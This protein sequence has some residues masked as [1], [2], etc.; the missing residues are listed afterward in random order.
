MSAHPTD[1]LAGRRVLVYCGGSSWDS[2]P[3]TDRHLATH[4]SDRVPV[5]YV[6]PP[7]SVVWQARH[8][9]RPTLRPGFERIGEQLYRLTPRSLPAVTRPGLRELAH[10]TT[11]LVLRQT[12]TRLRLDVVA[13]VV[14]SLDRL[15]VPNITSRRV[16][17]GT[18]DFVAGAHLMGLSPRWVERREPRALAEATHALAVSEVIADRWRGLGHQVVVVPN[19]CD[20]EAFKGTPETDPTP[21]VRLP[22]PRAVV[23]G[24]LSVRLDL[25]LLEDVVRAGRSLLL[26]GPAVDVETERRLAVLARSPHVQWVGRQPFDALPGFLRTADVGLTPYVDDAF[27]RASFPLKTLEYLAAGLPVVSTD[28]PAARALATDHVHV[29]TD[30]RDFVATTLRWLDQPRSAAATAARQEFAARHSWSTRAD[31]LLAAIG[32]ATRS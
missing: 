7:D 4:L 30:H 8:G 25:S 15:F 14:A 2:P 10:A 9:R 13:Q 22:E 6:D 3:G 20:T 17:Y 24:Q 26:V 21:D 29:A 16:L 5:L 18:D 19:G 31:E 32:L 23:V 1:A 12:V 28:L 27:N 11:R